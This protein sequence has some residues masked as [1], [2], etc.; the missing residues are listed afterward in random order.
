MWLPQSSLRTPV[1]VSSFSPCSIYESLSHVPCFFLSEVVSFTCRYVSGP[2][3]CCWLV[4]KCGSGE[5]QESSWWF[6][7]GLHICSWHLVVESF[8]ILKSGPAQVK[9]Y[10]SHSHI[11]NETEATGKSVIAKLLM[12]EAL[13]SS[14]IVYLLRSLGSDSIL[15]CFCFQHYSLV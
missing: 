10:H 15:L 8:C 5:R 13:Q 4:G 3:G 11:S 9:W 2:S 7:L 12:T 14:E 6:S 1:P